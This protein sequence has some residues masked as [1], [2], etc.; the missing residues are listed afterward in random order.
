MFESEALFK[1]VSAKNEVRRQR[2]LAFFGACLFLCTNFGQGIA[3]F[4]G[5]QIWLNHDLLLIL[6][7]TP[8]FMQIAFVWIS[9]ALSRFG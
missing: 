3:L 8:C 9:L 7:Y 4:E 2:S 5:N 6:I 1:A